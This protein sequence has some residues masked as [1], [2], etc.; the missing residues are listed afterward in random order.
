[1]FLG[2]SEGL[3]ERISITSYKNERTEFPVSRST[4]TK[5]LEKFSEVLYPTTTLLHGVLSKLHFHLISHVSYSTV[6]PHCQA[7]LLPYII[8]LESILGTGPA[9]TAGLYSLCQR[10]APLLTVQPQSSTP[11]RSP[12]YCSIRDRTTAT[13]GV[14]KFDNPHRRLWQELFKLH[15]AFCSCYSSVLN[16]PV[17]LSDLK[18]FL[19]QEPVFDLL[20]LTVVYSFFEL[21]SM[22]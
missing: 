21:P 19:D 15:I 11:R 1:M 13:L 17:P 7:S 18:T 9:A 10:I 8:P 5:S 4:G 6:L 14:L 20:T 3:D 22:I 12:M 16:T 2:I